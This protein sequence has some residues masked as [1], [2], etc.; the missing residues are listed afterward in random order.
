MPNFVSFVASVAEL[1]M[2]KNR[3]L[4]HSL[5]HPAYLMRQEPKISLRNYVAFL[6]ALHPIRRTNCPP[7][8]NQQ[9]KL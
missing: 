6:L 3:V 8:I 5:T 2:E 7:G 1:A 4:T 9:Q